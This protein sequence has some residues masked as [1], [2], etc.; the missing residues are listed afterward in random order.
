M[1]NFVP[2]L[3]TW[4]VVTGEGVFVGHVGTHLHQSQLVTWRV[5]EQD[6]HFLWFQHFSIKKVGSYYTQIVKYLN[7]LF[8]LIE[9]KEKADASSAQSDTSLKNP[10]DA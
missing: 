4:L 2:Q 6:C 3:A 8:F 7:N 1:H 9:E 5:V 10:K